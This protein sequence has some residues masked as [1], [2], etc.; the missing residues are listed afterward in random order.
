MEHEEE[1]YPATLIGAH[2]MTAIL[3]RIFH[4]P[5]LG[6]NCQECLVPVNGELPRLKTSGVAEFRALATFSV[7]LHQ[8]VVSLPRHAKQKSAYFL[9]LTVPS[10][11]ETIRPTKVR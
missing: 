10:V 4:V 3:P 8:Y 5:R 1:L 11:N 9:V 7:L 2:P 6:P